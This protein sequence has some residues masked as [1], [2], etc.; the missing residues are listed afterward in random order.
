VKEASSAQRTMDPC[1]ESDD[2]SARTRLLSLGAAPSRKS[3]D[4]PLSPALRVQQ[5]QR[6]KT[7]IS[8]FLK[9]KLHVVITDNRSVMI[10][11]QRDPRHE[12]YSVRLHHL[13]IDASEAVCRSLAQYIATNDQQASKDLNQ[14]IEENQHR[15]RN[16]ESEKEQHPVLRTQ[17]RCFELNQLFEELN[18]AYFAGQA[19]CD[20]TWG[21]H[22]GRGKYRRSIKVGSYSLEENLIR[23]HPGLD[24]DW[25]PRVY[26][27]WV[28]YHEMLHSKYPAPV[29]NGRHHFHTAD[30]AGQERLFIHYQQAITWEKRNIAALLSI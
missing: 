18:A 27:Q 23:I 13:F 17:G 30:F 5:A 2:R 20:I 28:I 21:K 19:S 7:G 11:I 9:G 8:P 15:I 1:Q 26:L 6:I 10:S 22:A 25:I 24:Q 29:V 16:L 14:F 4:L 12:Q 3:T